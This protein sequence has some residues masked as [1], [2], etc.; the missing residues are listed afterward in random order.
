MLGAAG[1][2]IAYRAKPIVQERSDY[3]INYCGLDAILNLL[4]S[5]A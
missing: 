5:P 3:A 2:S 1:I 4:D